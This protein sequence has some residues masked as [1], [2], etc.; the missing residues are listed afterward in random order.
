MLW[1]QMLVKTDESMCTS[2]Y[3]WKARARA[4]PKSAPIHLSLC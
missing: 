4:D 2:N 1:Q 3:C